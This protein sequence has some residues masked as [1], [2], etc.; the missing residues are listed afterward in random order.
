MIILKSFSGN[1][2]SIKL[3]SVM[4][5]NQSCQGE[6]KCLNVTSREQQKQNFHHLPRVIIKVYF[7]V[8]DLVIICVTNRFNKPGYIQ[9][10][11]ME[12]LLMLA[13][14]GKDF[15][16]KLKVITDFYLNDFDDYKLDLQLNVLS[17]NFKDNYGS[18]SFNDVKEY[19]TSL[20][21]TERIYYSHY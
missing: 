7:E 8:L 11:N 4:L 15:K 21:S 13:A 19:L 12:E 3:H 20:T 18:L 16:E 14:N 6:E 2:S 1:C 9:Y 10:K 17:A 5:Q